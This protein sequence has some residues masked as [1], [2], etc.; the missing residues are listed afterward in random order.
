MD[1]MLCICFHC[2]LL[3][4]SLRITVVHA[5]DNSFDSPLARCSSLERGRWHCASAKRTSRLH[6]ETPDLV[7][8]L[9]GFLLLGHGVILGTTV[10]LQVFILQASGWRF[11]HQIQ[12]LTPCFTF[13]FNDP[14]AP[15]AAQSTSDCD[16]RVLASV[17][18]S[19]FPMWK[20]R[21]KNKVY[22]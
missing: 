21:D 8:I 22:K 11:I 1:N 15:C 13:I 17:S 12:C 19:G 9:G 18:H 16:W 14:W 4:L 5:Q 10:P 3:D 7:L 2:V 6:I 20:Q